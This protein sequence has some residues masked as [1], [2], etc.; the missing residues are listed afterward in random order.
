MQD[1]PLSLSS[2]G[3]ATTVA[4]SQP[5][6]SSARSSVLVTS[7]AFIVVQSFQAMMYRL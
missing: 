4:L 3:L 6:M 1:E 5:D 7:S 2:L